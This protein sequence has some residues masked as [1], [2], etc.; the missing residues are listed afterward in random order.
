MNFKDHYYTTLLEKGVNIKSK[1]K[2][3]LINMFVLTINEI[4]IFN[5]E[6]VTGSDEPTENYHPNAVTLNYTEL[7]HYL[8]TYC[9]GQLFS[10]KALINLFY[11]SCPAPYGRNIKLLTNWVDFDLISLSQFD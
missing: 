11:T 10:K 3:A 8:L 2:A 6:G 9:F 5:E 7:F 4:T 1:F